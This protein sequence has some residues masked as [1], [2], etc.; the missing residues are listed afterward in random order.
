LLKSLDILNRI[1]Y[2]LIAFL[3]ANAV[4]SQY[5]VVRERL[6][7]LPS[8]DKK[9][10]HYGYFLGLNQ[11]DFKFEYIQNY[12]KELMLKDI[13]VEQQKGFSVGLI[14]DLRINEYMNLR[15]EPGLF[16]NKRDLIYPEYEEFTKEN[17]RYRDIKSTYIHL[18]L[19]LK[20]STKRIN[21]FRPFIV[22]GFS[23]DFNLSSNQKNSDDNASN[24]F[25]VMSQNINY[26]L[27]LGFD[28]YLYYFKFSPS[29]RGI[30]SMQNELIPDNDPESPWTGKINNMFSRGV[31]LIITFE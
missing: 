29:L 5:P 17:D 11:Y 23:T 18:P 25:R 10:V 24:V 4:H 15:F 12:Y 13:A 2:V 16:Y 7:N 20:I 27:G 3:F 22:G 14:G 19:L 9:P 21:N 30:F 26:E 31:A 6:I 28:F 8:F 1:K